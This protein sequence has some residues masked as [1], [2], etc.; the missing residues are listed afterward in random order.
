MSAVVVGAVLLGLLG[1]V[2]CAGVWIGMSLGIV[3]WIGLE[4]FT[5]TS[6]GRSSSRRSGERTLVGIGGAAV[7][8]L[9]GR[10]SVPHAVV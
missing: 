4:G 10:D 7:I 8:Y 2:L 6:P 5:D 1:V 9:D 3:G